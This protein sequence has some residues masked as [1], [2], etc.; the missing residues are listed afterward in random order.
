MSISKYK[1]RDKKVH[2]RGHGGRLTKQQRKVKRLREE[3]RQRQ[4]RNILPE[5]QREMPP[6]ELEHQ[7]RFICVNK[8]ARNPARRSFDIS[9]L[10]TAVTWEDIGPILTGSISLSSP[11]TALN[12][13]WQG[14]SDGSVI[15]CQVKMGAK[16]IEIW[17]MRIWVPSEELESASGTFRLADDLRLL[18]QNEDDFEYKKS[19]KD[20]RHKKG[21]EPWEVVLDVLKRFRVRAGRLAKPKLKH[22]ITDLTD[23]WTDPLSI[24]EKAYDHASNENGKTYILRWR[25][26][27]LNVEPLRRQPVLYSMRQQI[28][29]AVITHNRGKKFYTALTVTASRAKHKSKKKEKIEVEVVHNRAVKRYGYI[30]GKLDL[31]REFDSEEAVRKQGKRRLAREIRRKTDNTITLSHPGIPFIRRGDAIRVHLPEFGF[32][33]RQR[34]KKVYK[35]GYF[36]VLFVK[37]VTHTATTGSYTMDIEFGQQDAYAEQLES[38][39]EARDKDRRNKKRKERKGKSGGS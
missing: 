37:S 8:A 21:W 24:I 9:R 3:R 32:T 35:G 34:P 16:W 26:G 15:K 14:V 19:K 25:N 12:Q 28:L 36:S 38:M 10:V 22:K 33:D 6:F 2:D 20:R 13:P 5:Y 29:S 18:R 23:P 27:R 39:R 30:H 11:Q 17:R 7:F 31:K 4:D 1:N